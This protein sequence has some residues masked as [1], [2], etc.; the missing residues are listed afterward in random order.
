MATREELPE[1]KLPVP[2]R[3]KTIRSE[4]TKALPLAVQ[5]QQV[6]LYFRLI[7]NGL[8]LGAAL[9]KLGGLRTAEACGLRFCDIEV[10]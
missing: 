3:Q 1:L 2:Y 5:V 9:M 10:G 7:S 6:A 4:H 8:M